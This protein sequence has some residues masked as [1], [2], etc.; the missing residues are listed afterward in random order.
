M[1]LPEPGKP[2]T[3][4]NL[5]PMPDLSKGITPHNVFGLPGVLGAAKTVT[6][7]MAWC[8]LYDTILRPP[9][10]SRFS[11][12]GISLPAGG[13][14]N[15]PPFVRNRK[16]R[17]IDTVLALLPLHLLGEGVVRSTPGTLRASIV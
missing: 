12:R 6:S 2:H 1:V 8:S 4:I 3:I 15:Q 10:D 16:A 13:A 7:K 14:L 9:E 17:I 5:G 11:L